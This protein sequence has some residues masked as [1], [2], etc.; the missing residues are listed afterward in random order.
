MYH[1]SHLIQH[2][3]T[4][5]NAISDDEALFLYALCRAMRLK[6]IV[7]L[8]TSTGYSANNFL[9]SV[10]SF[11]GKVVSIDK[12]EYKNAYRGFIF[13]HKDIKNIVP[14]DIPMDNIDLIFFDTHDSDGQIIFFE[15][16]LSSQKITD[17]TII[18]I[19]DTGAWSLLRYGFKSDDAPERRLNNYLVSKGWCPLHIHK[20]NNNKI[21][22]CY[23]LTIMSKNNFYYK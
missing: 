11:D 3:D 23:G 2:L 17:K 8:G 9:Q 21:A 18:A 14:D 19:H 4:V 1:M 6:N 13:I 7:E 12:N 10:S 16:M 5:P 22:F 15:T 20:R